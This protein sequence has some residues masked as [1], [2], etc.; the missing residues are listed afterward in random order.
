MVARHRRAGLLEADLR[1][2]GVRTADVLLQPS[3]RPS[4]PIR[5][6][7]AVLRIGGVV[8]GDLELR[9]WLD[10]RDRP[11]LKELYGAG[12]GGE[13]DILMAAEE[14]LHGSGERGQV[15]QLFIAQRRLIVLLFRHLAAP[16][17]AAGSE[18]DHVSL[19]LDLSRHD[20][21]CLRID[22]EAID[23]H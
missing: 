12:Y 8:P 16:E 10:R 7:P 15:G 23:W 13:L 21:A 3:V 9:R 22:S 17:T 5:Q 14:L 20:V 4:C 18:R 6:D 1:A 2:L 19:A 11:R